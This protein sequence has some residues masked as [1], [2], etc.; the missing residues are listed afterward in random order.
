M[1][2]VW[3]FGCFELDSGERRLSKN[4][5]PVPLP[6]K[7]F[8]LLT[9]LVKSAGNLVLR[10][11]LLETVWPDSEVEDANLT[12]NITALRK[13]L[14]PRAIESVPKF[15]YR[16]C[17]PVTA[18]PA[19][20]PTASETLREGCAQMA[21]RTNEAVLA[22]RD[23]FWLV[24]AE[25]PEC[26]EAWAWLGRACRF[27]EKFKVERA[28]H[29]KIAEAAF[30]RAFALDPDLASAHRFYTNLQ[31]DRGEATEALQRLL[32][33]IKQ[34][35]DDAPSFAALVQVC[36]FCGLL[37]ASEAAHRI[38]TQLD[39]GI[40][41]SIPHTHF[42]RCDYHA[43][44]EAYAASA[45]G[46]RGYL[47]LAAWSCLGSEERAFREGAQ[48]LADLSLPL[49]VRSLLGSLLASLRRDTPE[50]ERICF[51]LELYEDP[52]SVL[53]FAR[54][55]A[56]S[57]SDRHALDF[58]RR[59]VEGGLAVPDMLE[60]DPWLD[61]IRP[62]RTFREILRQAR[63]QRERAERELFR[64]HVSQILFAAKPRQR[65]A[66]QRGAC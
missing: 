24:I 34:H 38:A 55:L 35:R 2:A 26:A 47:D 62:H 17:F 63:V 23:S 21:R 19:L 15:G 45:A 37:D 4:G 12:N 49:A 53:Y 10:K 44:I 59:A 28:Y 36:R 27:L 64:A 30:Q 29:R 42:A 50:V 39:P 40:V 51:S 7:A 61:S 6:P 13:I 16:F 33:R 18:P 65:V 43:V 22:A 58:L 25:S 20:S 5:K 48:R 11:T 54:H 66:G 3:R 60:R 57:G 8:D 31:V 14:G 32:R 9:L 46:A 52:E 1:T 41:T 56:Y